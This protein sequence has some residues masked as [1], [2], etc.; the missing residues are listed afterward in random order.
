MSTDYPTNP[1]CLTHPTNTQRELTMHTE[2]NK[3]R[4]RPAGF[5]MIELLVVITIIAILGAVAVP[6]F[7]K[8]PEKARL[9]RAQ[10]EVNM[11]QMQANAFQL[12]NGKPPG[13][14]QDLVEYFEEGKFPA[15]DPWGG[16]Y[17]MEQSKDGVRVKCPN[18]DAKSGPVRGDGQIGSSGG[19]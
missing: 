12:D 2:L 11:L 17:V 7:M 3:R 4:C 15:K 8:N 19:K 10:L 9:S 5:T 6:R 13:S 1:T 14:L 18:L 16:E